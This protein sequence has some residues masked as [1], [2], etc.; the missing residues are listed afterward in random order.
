[1]EMYGDSQEE[2][3][4]SIERSDAARKSYYESVTNKRWGDSHGY[5]LCVD[6]SIG[7][8][9]TAELVYSYITAVY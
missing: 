8:E 6:S 7:V 3:V 1:M 2:A 5:E 9:E 4:K